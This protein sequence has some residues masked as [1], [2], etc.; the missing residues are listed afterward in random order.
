MTFRCG[1]KHCIAAADARVDLHKQVLEI[2]VAKQAGPYASDAVAMTALA[3]AIERFAQ[4]DGDHTTSIPALTLH[5][6]KAPT[7]PLHCIYNLG[8]VVVAQ[9][10]KQ[11][12]LGGKAI[13]Y[14]PGQS[15]LTTIDLPV[16]SHVTRATAREPFLG[17]MLTLDVRSIADSLRDGR[18][19][20]AA[21]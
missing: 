19:S 3:R 15:M 14:G 10:G 12:L 17:L 16:I 8:L 6:R 1:N 7:E 4:T 18:A 9:G 2:A 11:I 13:D 21:R 5:R 20:V